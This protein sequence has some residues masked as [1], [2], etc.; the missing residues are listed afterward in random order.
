MLCYLEKERSRVYPHFSKKSFMNV[1]RYSKVPASSILFI[2]SI[3]FFLQSLF[4]ISFPPN[5]RTFGNDKTI[6][7]HLF[8]IVNIL[9]I[10]YND[11]W[12]R[13]MPE[14]S[15]PELEQSLKDLFNISH[16]IA[17]V[18]YNFSQL[19]T[20]SNKRNNSRHNSRLRAK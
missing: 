10:L 8:Y 13:P 2:S 16:K 4:S 14:P 15:P 20:V 17:C 19:S 3:I 18:L 5:I 7:E 12:R 9:R 1:C 6:I 11:L